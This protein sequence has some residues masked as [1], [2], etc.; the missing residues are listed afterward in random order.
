MQRAYS[1]LPLPGWQLHASGEETAQK[2]HVLAV[3]LGLPL[4]DTHTLCPPPTAALP[5]TWPVSSSPVG[6]GSGACRPTSITS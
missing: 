2:R 3:A 6:T 1:V 4:S 5:R